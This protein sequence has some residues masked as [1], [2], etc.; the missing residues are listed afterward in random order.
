ML[1]RKFRYLVLLLV[2][3]SLGATPESVQTES[4][5]S[6]YPRSIYESA[7]LALAHHP[8]VRKQE[9]VLA[10]QKS[11]QTIVE[12]TYLPKVSLNLGIGREDSNTLSTRSRPAGSSI[13]LER[14][15]A[16]IR[17]QQMLFDGF[18][19]RWQSQSASERSEALQWERRYVLGDLALRA[20]VVHLELWRSLRLQA[21]HQKHLDAHSKILVDVESRIRSGKDE[22]ARRSHTQA[23]LARAEAALRAVQSELAGIREI[24]RQLT[25]V[26]AP[27]AL[28]EVSFDHLVLPDSRDEF[29]A[30]VHANN[31]LLLSHMAAQKSARSSAKSEEGSL[32]PTVLV[33]TGANWDAN[34]DGTP[35]RNSDAYVMLRLNYDLYNGGSDRARRF[36]LREQAELVRYERE[37]LQQELERDAR[38]AWEAWLGQQQQWQSL[39]SSLQYTEETHLS[40]Y[41]QFAIGQ[42]SL[43]E[44][45]DM[46]NEV[47][48]ARV[49]AQRVEADLVISRLRIVWF[50]GQLL[51]RLADAG[52]VELLQ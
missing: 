5:R 10:I 26:A 20:M 50:S 6:I 45:L 49:Q 44:L 46:E 29:L 25:G 14:R 38:M 31:A 23:R 4:S 1:L 47:L 9:A 42:R 52:A 33:E 22:V 19:T 40:Y 51:T 28:R 41:R 21:F 27:E 8:E 35:G 18:K 3:T 11:E 30:D 2:S 34:I 7:A 37:T 24:F 36:K 15:E 43:T 32:Y 12:S 39:Q 17:V 13:E 48:D 16:G